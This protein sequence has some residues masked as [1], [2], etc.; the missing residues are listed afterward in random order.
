MKVSMK[1]KIVPLNPKTGKVIRKP[2]RGQSVQYAV[3][4]PRGGIKKL[5]KVPPQAFAKKDLQGINRSIS[6]GKEFILYE[7][8]TRR[9]VRDKKG[10]PVPTT[11]TDPKTGKPIYKRQTKITFLQPSEKQ[12]PALYSAG[13]RRRA[14][15]IG[16]QTHSKRQQADQKN[17]I[18][19]TPDVTP[20]MEYVVRGASVRNALSDL[21][22]ALDRDK[23][24]DSKGGKVA[25]LYYNI[26]I[27]LTK[28]DGE[29]IRIP[30]SG[31]LPVL[32]RFKDVFPQLATRVYRETGETAFR[33]EVG[34]LTNLQQEL[35]WAVSHSLSNVGYRFTSLKNLKKYAGQMGREVKRLAKDARQ[36]RQSG[37]VALA[38]RK[39]E[40]MAKVTKA[41]NDMLN[42]MS[43][44]R[45]ITGEYE[46]A[47][48]LEFET[49]PVK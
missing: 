45:M 26:I 24:Y 18:V 4:G 30:A 10:R 19:V 16:F 42:R 27:K 39:E 22:L 35:G 48:Q 12:R 49:I 43:G 40:S 17:M 31:A 20:P 38:E 5:A 29:I 15:G 28:P 44:K 11:K 13:K 6:G 36:A 14:L 3:Q 2:K 7:Q 32:E 41:R 8:L 34:T 9:Y 47:L 25:G 23:V 1:Y 33:K 46:L 37:K 21:V